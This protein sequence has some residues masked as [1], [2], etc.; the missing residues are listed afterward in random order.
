MKKHYTPKY[1]PGDILIRTNDPHV[2]YIK[3]ITRVTDD[4]YDFI[5]CGSI[6][7]SSRKMSM[8]IDSVE[9]YSILYTDFFRQGPQWKRKKM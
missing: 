4:Y 1:K 8:P 9:E 5:Y 7:K 3:Y 6:N 2:L